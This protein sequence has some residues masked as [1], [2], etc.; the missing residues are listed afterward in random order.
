MNWSIPVGYIELNKKYITDHAHSQSY[1]F[2]WDNIKMFY[3][4]YKVYFQNIHE[5]AWTY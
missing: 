4:T 2:S 5:L 1:S 3:I